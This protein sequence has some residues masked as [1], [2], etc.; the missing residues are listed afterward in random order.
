M[1]TIQMK[2]REEVDQLLLDTCL[3]RNK[4]EAEFNDLVRQSLTCEEAYNE[5][6]DTAVRFHLMSDPTIVDTTDQ[7]FIDLLEKR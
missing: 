5:A 2:S 6:C 4:F 1:N 3:S 7:Y